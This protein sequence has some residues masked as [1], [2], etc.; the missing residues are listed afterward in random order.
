MAEIVAY[1]VMGAIIMVCALVLWRFVSLF[2]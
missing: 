1:G 2:E